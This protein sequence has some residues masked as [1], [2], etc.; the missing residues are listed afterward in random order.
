MSLKEVKTWLDGYCSAHGDDWSPTL[1][2]WKMIKD[3]ILS[4]DEEQQQGCVVPAQPA[5]GYGNYNQVPALR[6][7]AQPLQ[8]SIVPMHNMMEPDIG[9]S[10]VGVTENPGIVHKDGRLATTNSISGEPSN[11]G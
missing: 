4:L 11:F 10:M 3:K 9:H 7:A 5:Q 2:Q 6:Y 1:E 8:S